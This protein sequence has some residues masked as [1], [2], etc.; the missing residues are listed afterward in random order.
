MKAWRI[1]GEKL[2]P[3]SAGGFFWAGAWLNQYSLSKIPISYS[4]TSP[5]SRLFVLTVQKPERIKFFDFGKF[6]I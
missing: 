6:E 4:S 2:S 1:A 3:R 5:H